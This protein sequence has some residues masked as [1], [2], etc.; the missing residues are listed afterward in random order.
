MKRWLEVTIPLTFLTLAF[1]L[2]AYRYAKVKSE[3]ELLPYH[4]EKMV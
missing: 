1:G 3:R 4:S 2:L